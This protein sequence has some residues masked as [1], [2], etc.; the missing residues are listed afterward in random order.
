M[1]ERR[2]ES[3]VRL[4]PGSGLHCFPRLPSAASVVT[5]ECVRGGVHGGVA[6]DSAL[7]PVMVG[8]LGHSLRA[9]TR[10]VTSVLGGA[11]RARSAIAKRRLSN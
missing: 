6:C 10:S 3:R 1:E 5:V 7:R 2:A 9:P 11:W 8:R 4:S